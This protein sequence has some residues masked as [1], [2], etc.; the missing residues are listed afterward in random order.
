[1]KKEIEVMSEFEIN[2]PK[3]INE[4]IEKINGLYDEYHA[5]L[6]LNDDIF[7]CINMIVAKASEEKDKQI[8]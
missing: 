4:F 7:N 3:R 5:E 6:Y 2:K 1:M 8:R